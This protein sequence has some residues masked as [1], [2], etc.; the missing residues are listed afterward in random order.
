MK[1]SELSGSHSGENLVEV[2]QKM[3][4]QLQIEERVLIIT[5]DNALNNE[6]L[7]AEL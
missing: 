1:F 5:A 6:T 7:A 3:L 4:V 2:L